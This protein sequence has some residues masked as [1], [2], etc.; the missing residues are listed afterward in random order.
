MRLLV[1][2]TEYPPIFSSGIGNV[3]YEVSKKLKERKIETIVCSP[4]GPDIKLGSALLIQKFGIIGLLYY[5]YQVS[6]YF[7]K[8][9]FDAVWL[10]NPLLIRDNPFLRSVI[11]IHTT[12]YGFS[13]QGFNPKI[14]YKIASIIEK[15]CINK[16][17]EKAKFT[18]VDPFVCKEL[19]EM[20]INTRINF[21]PNGVDTKQFKPSNC[22]KLLRINFGIPEEDKII[23]SIGRL[24]EIK[25]PLKLIEVFSVIEKKM[26]NVTLVIAGK[27]ELLNEVKKLLKKND[28]KKVIFLGY[29]DQEK[30]ADLYACSDFY[31]MPSKYEGQPLSLLE[32][33]SSGLS[34]IVSGI[35][36]LKIVEDADCGIIVDFS[37]NER[38]AQKIIDYVK[39]DN[40]VH[41]I[42]ARKYAENNLDWSIITGKYLKEFETTINTV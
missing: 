38:A 34:C 16:L 3:A 9:N 17:H 42:N 6:K 20:G 11:T 27:G 37:D 32:A 28:L 13:I 36:N 31:I 29:V 4:T 1:C 12:Y 41:S 2:L 7:R 25:Q 8:N 15:Y 26:E 24:T 18:V 22:K 30:K 23:L 35:P 14:Y 39:K 5:W 40:S 10:H 21:V 19:E 33:I